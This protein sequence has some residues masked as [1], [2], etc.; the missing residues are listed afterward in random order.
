MYLNLL[1][2]YIPVLFTTIFS[3]KKTHCLHDNHN[4][5]VPTSDIYKNSQQNLKVKQFIDFAGCF[6]IYQLRKMLTVEKRKG[7]LAQYR[8][9]WSNSLQ[10]L[11]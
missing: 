9:D 6:Y 5:F 2:A 10:T 8:S 7:Y 4:R 11:S 3:K 1:I